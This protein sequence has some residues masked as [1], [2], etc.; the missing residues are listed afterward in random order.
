MKEPSPVEVKPRRLARLL[1]LAAL[2]A[3]L[4]AIGV[5]ALLVTIVERR[6]E[7]KNPF[8]RVVELDERTDDPAVW[9]RNFPLQYDFYLRTVDQVRTRFGGSEALPRTPTD[10]DPRSVVARSKI[11]EDPRLKTLWAG[12]AFSVDYREERGHAYMLEDQSYTERQRVVKQPGTCLNCH[13]STHVAYL[14]L[15]E[16]DLFQ[17]FDRLNAMPW[18]EAR[19]YVRHPV[20]CVDCH[21][22][23]SMELRITRPA[24]LEGMR[25]LRAAQGVSDYDV[26]R[27]STRQEMRSFGCGQCHVEYYFKGQGKRLVYPWAKGLHVEDA[28]AYY[29]EIDF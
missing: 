29:D 18:A 16:G 27:D 2:G 8:F 21:D 11:E 9:G 1:L 10:V 15:G 6:Q 23:A 22:P 13:A 26:N 4:A 17:G 12:Y 19:Q 3:A 7:A 20:S 25:A 28:L 24:F 5:A 14:T